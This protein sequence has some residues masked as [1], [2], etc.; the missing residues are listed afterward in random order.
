[1]IVLLNS[2][3]ELRKKVEDQAKEIQ[4]LKDEINRLKGEQGKPNISG[5]QKG[6]GQSISSERERKQPKQWGKEGKKDKIPIDK[7]HKCTLSK[8]A[9]P[10]DAYFLRYDEYV[11]Q[12]LKLV[13]ENTRY[14]IA[15]YYSPTLQ[16]TYRASLPE[17]VKGHFGSD[18]KTIIHVLTHV[19]DVTQSKLLQLLRTAGIEISTG[20][21]NN[22]LLEQVSM[23]ESEKKAILRAG[24]SG[25]YCG[26]DST[27]SK[28]KG[29]RLYTQ[30]INNEFFSI[31]SSRNSKSRLSV[32]STLQ[33]IREVEL[34]MVYNQEAKELL[35]YFSLAQADKQAIEIIFE[36]NKEYAKA[37][38]E[39]LVTEQIPALK[40]KKNMFNRLL[41][42]L[43]I[44]GYHQQI[45]V[46]AV[47]NLITDD[48][49]EYKK[50]AKQNH[51]LCWVHDAGFYTKLTPYIEAHRQ[52]LKEFREC[53]WQYYH[54]L[55]DY[56]IKPDIQKAK[57]LNRE[58][59]DIFIPKTDYFQLNR[60]IERTYANKSKLLIVLDNPFIPLHN[61]A[62]ELAARRIVTKR[63]IH[64][65]TVS[66]VG[67]TV[68]D[69]AMS[70]VETAK[71]LQVN[72]IDYLNDR[73]SGSFDMPSLANTI[74][75]HSR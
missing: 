70:V 26:M 14:L 74:L 55:L 39:Q 63:N 9:L 68:K 75:L 47:N 59:D 54:R 18:L 19:C 33:G 66:D 43:A 36:N 49:G 32:L 72:V 13:R 37:E 34:A 1:M 25:R 23:Y 44:A 48:A 51:A 5:N 64:L 4:R 30:I 20:S 42:A 27:C 3:E 38:V 8:A 45:N 58:F 60:C 12:D 11:Q 62:S 6:T 56:K 46:P 41:E 22:I 24:L 67:T 17:K 69:A 10:P 29:Q 52:I 40:A 15:V 71:K 53:Y 73:I 61:N 21:I 50:L 2:N 35:N 57:K 7:E 28:Q 65:H 31:F 16:K